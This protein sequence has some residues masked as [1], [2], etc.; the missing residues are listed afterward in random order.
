MKIV[1]AGCGKIGQSMIQSLVIEGHEIVVID[2]DSEVIDSIT[3]NYDVMG[4]CQ[5][6][7]SCKA[8]IDANV[9]SAELFIAATD[10]D[11]INM[12]SCFLAK[13][14]G[15]KHTV[16]RIRSGEYSRGDLDF[17]KKQLELSMV[18]NPERLTAR[19]IYDILKFPSAVKCES[20]TRSRFEM[21]EM[22]VKPDSSLDG[23]S[24]SELRTRSGASFL[25]CAVL[26]GKTAHIPR[27]TFVLRGGDRIGLIAAPEDMQKLLNNLGI[28][29]KRTKHVFLLG[30]SRIAGYLSE[31]LIRSGNSVKIIE[32]DEKRCDDISARLGGGAVV[33]HGDG[34][35]HEVLDEEGI[36]SAD[37]FV[38]LTGMDEENL[39]LSYYALDHGVPKVVAKLNQDAYHELGEHLGIECTVSPKRITADV[40]LQYAR[41]LQNSMGSRVETLYSLMNGTVEALEFAVSPEFEYTGI[42]LKSLRIKPDILLAGIIRGSR[43]IIP[44]GDDIIE[45]DDRVIIIAA[46]RKLYDLSDVI[47]Q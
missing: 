18:I 16:A 45:P 8:L 7:T 20:F 21:A 27:G 3:T 11:E 32:K 1:I 22:Y 26:R 17:I 15:A 35:Q 4:I 37:A 9:G 41:A 38:A 40:I 2:N 28:L 25:V 34:S 30:A 46:G 13:R 6:A 29:Q 14:M 23:A 36:A 12:L 39:L 43:N 19:A 31:D 24:L 10:S 42:P 47:E 5:S 44:G 33:I